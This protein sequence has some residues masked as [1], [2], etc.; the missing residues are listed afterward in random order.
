MRSQRGIIAAAALALVAVGCGG[1]DESAGSAPASADS[2]V[3]AT[4]AGP[5]TT[6]P[7]TTAPAT[8]ASAST[9]PP[10]TTPV[11]TVRPT[12]APVTTAPADVLDR[13]PGVTAIVVTA[14][15][16]DPTRP[17]FSWPEVP[18]AT[19]YELVVHAADGTP[20]W[21]WTGVAATV[22]LGGVERGV[23]EQGPTLTG[24]AQ[25]RVYALDAASRLVGVSPWTSV[26]P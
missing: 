25:V 7:A 10:T 13:Q 3:A 12:S 17:T 9:A 20:L 1:S 23:D 4:T 2:V 21:A 26:T 6:E 18:G 16:G 22:P 19:A 24:P 11:T 8:T 15:G 14:S 5:A